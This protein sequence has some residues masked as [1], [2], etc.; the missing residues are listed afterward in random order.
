MPCHA[1]WHTAADDVCHTS[2]DS[3]TAARPLVVM[4]FP[5]TQRL[6][7]EGQPRAIVR[8]QL[9]VNQSTWGLQRVKHTT[10]RLLVDRPSLVPGQLFSLLVAFH[11][12]L[13]TMN[14]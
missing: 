10:V 8:I 13:V 5:P 7:R 12:Q 1:T 3:P 4:A 6:L 14:P 2:C 9:S 11:S